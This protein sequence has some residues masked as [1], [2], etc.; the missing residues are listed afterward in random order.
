[1]TQTLAEAIQEAYEKG[2][3]NDPDDPWVDLDCYGS[4][5]PRTTQ[6]YNCEE[7]PLEAH[8][9]EAWDEAQSGVGMQGESDFIKRW[10]VPLVWL[11]IVTFGTYCLFFMR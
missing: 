6:Q 8:C 10:V 2:W 1:M 11:I 5:D 3:V 4:T 7:C 9:C